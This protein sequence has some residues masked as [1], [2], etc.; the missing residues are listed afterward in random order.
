MPRSPFLPALGLAA[1]LMLSSAPAL[2]QSDD[3]FINGYAAAILAREFALSDAVLTV[4]DGTLRVDAPVIARSRLPQLRQ[5]LSSIPGVTAVS[6]LEAGEP[7]AETTLGAPA[8]EAAP[9]AVPIAGGTAAAVTADEPQVLARSTLFDPILADRRWPHFSASYHYWS[10]DPDVEHAGAVSFGETFSLYRAPAP[11][12][13]RWELGFQAGVFAV[14]DLDSESSDLINADYAV[15]IPVIY[16]RG[17]FSALARVF[18]QSSHLG[19][20]FLLRDDIDQDRRINLSYEGVDAILSYDVTESWRLYGGA[21]YL[22][23]REPDELEPWATQAGVEWSGTELVAGSLR[24]I[25]AADVQWFEENDW[26]PDF[27]LRAGFQIENPRL[28][29]QTIQITGEYY[30]GRNPNGQ[31]FSRDLEYYGVGVHL[32]FQ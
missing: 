1:G 2:A 9:A 10:D 7:V 18:H 23:R 14:F 12:N 11:F 17:D 5:A 3:A 30:N 28:I 29:S 27:S 20:E 6:I 21:S 32:Y 31:F 13:G 19:D 4:R 16:R 8:A 24:P 25:A 26:D 15:A 22:F